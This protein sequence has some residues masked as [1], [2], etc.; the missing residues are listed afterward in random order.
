MEN[1]KQTMTNFKFKDCQDNKEQCYILLR[2]ATAH[3]ARL[4][5][6]EFI[7]LVTQSTHADEEVH[8]LFLRSTRVKDSKATLVLESRELIGLLKKDGDELLTFAFDDSIVF[9]SKGSFEI[10][11]GDRE[12]WLRE[13]IN[14]SNLMR[15]QVIGSH[16]GKN[17]DVE[18]IAKYFE[19]V[20]PTVM[21]QIS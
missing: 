1:R 18:E 15:D 14:F 11:E 19:K 3:F 4:S 6:T 21:R 2:G 10:E 7:N 12:M 13:E 8:D 9:I 5:K 17:G 16:N 20:R